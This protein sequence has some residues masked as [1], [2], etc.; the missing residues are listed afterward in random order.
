VFGIF[1]AA[2]VGTTA[3]IIHQKRIRGTVP[4][5]TKLDKLDKL[6]KIHSKMSQELAKAGVKTVIHLGRLIPGMITA[7]GSIPFF[8]VAAV[9]SHDNMF[10]EIMVSGFAIGGLCAIIIGFILIFI[11]FKSVDAELRG[12]EQAIERERFNAAAHRYRR[13]AKTCQKRGHIALAEHFFNLA[14]QVKAGLIDEIE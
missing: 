4:H 12:A 2:C 11:A 5:S 7:L 6:K 9:I 8:V 1:V 13:I 10:W 3:V 14:Q